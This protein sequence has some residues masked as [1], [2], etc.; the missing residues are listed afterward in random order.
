MRNSVL[1]E[2][3]QEA[4]YCGNS[5]VYFG[6]WEGSAYAVLWDERESKREIIAYRMTPSRDFDK[7]CSVEKQRG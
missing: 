1:D 7:I 3:S 5:F 4:G 2:F 6:Q